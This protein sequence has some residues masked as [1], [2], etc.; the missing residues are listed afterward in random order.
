MSGIKSRHDGE[1]KVVM[2]RYFWMKIFENKQSKYGTYS[3]CKICKERKKT[4]NRI[5]AQGGERG[6][7]SRK[8][9][10]KCNERRRGEVHK[11]ERKMKKTEKNRR[12]EK[13]NKKTREQRTK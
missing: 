6:Q 7:E 5:I 3:G 2:G 13:L 4:T 1:G 12:I 11:R 9:R 10:R 8:E